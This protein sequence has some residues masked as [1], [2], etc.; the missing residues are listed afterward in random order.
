MMRLGSTRPGG[1]LLRT[2]GDEER[3]CCGGC[4]AIEGTVRCTSGTGS[5]GR[6]GGG[7][8]VPTEIGKG[9]IDLPARA[10]ASDAPAARRA[11]RWLGGG[12][13]SESLTTGTSAELP[14]PSRASRFV[15]GSRG[16][17]LVGRSESVGR[18]G[19]GS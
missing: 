6:V 17:G 9:V 16:S 10:G 1:K 19:G 8:A 2:G 7:S 11:A 13:R 12:G 14:P 15:I 18:A 4:G 5:D 3:R